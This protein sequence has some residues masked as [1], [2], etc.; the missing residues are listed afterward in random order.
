L[1]MKDLSSIWGSGNFSFVVVLTTDSRLI[2]RNDCYE[3]MNSYFL[4]LFV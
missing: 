3:E 2:N 4:M 1:G